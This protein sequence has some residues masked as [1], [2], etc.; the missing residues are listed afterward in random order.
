MNIKDLI[1]ELD[2]E[3]V[4]EADLEK[5]IK[6]AYSSDLLSNVMART[7]EGDLWLTV[8]GHQNIVAIALLNDL[9]AVITTEEF[10]AD[11][12]ARSKAQ[13]QGINL[14]KTTLS[15]YELSGEL[16][17]LGIGQK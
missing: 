1:E 7:K 8:Q 16:Y 15:S 3:V 5:E 11:E 4:V 14:L 10:E 9:A 17:K 12:E 2:L 6:G 13:N